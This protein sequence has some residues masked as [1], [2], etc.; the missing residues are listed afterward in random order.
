MC[1]RVAACSIC[2][3]FCTGH[4][5]NA[6]KPYVETSCPGVMVPASGHVRAQVDEDDDERAGQQHLQRV[7]HRLRLGHLDAAAPR[8]LRLLAVAAREHAL[9]A[10]AAQD[11][12]ARDGVGAERRQPAGGLA[13]RRLAPRQ[14]LDQQAEDRGDG[15]QAEDH[16]EAER[17]RDA[18]HED[19]DDAVRDEAAEEV[20]GQRVDLADAQRVV[21]DGRDDL[22]RRQL[23]RDRVA[24][25]RDGPAD[26]L[27]GRERG[28]QPVRDVVP[29]ADGRRGGD[30]HA[31][32]QQRAARAPQVGAE[33][34]ARGRRRSRGRRRTG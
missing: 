18:Q 9:A 23:R 4:D 12:Q 21:G 27:G 1:A 30:D 15:R 32:R 24:R 16:D 34:A 26:Q 19:G 14:R 2:V 28:A 33:A 11:A 31:E 25:P 6:A 20:G 10:D 5:R 22:A 29:V 8:L 13:L 7:E 17:D 3:A